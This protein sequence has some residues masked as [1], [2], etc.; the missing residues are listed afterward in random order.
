MKGEA[1]TKVQDDTESFTHVIATLGR[2]DYSR[3]MFVT[4]SL[5]T[6]EKVR[7]SNLLANWYP[8]ITIEALEES[9]GSTAKGMQ[10]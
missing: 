6:L 2:Q 7:Q 8:L 5:S 1:W 4:E 3:I 10:E 9:P